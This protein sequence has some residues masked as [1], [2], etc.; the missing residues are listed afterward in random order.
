M[1]APPLAQSIP[2]PLVEMSPA[3]SEIGQ[4][5]ILAP[6]MAP[7]IPGPFVERAMTPQENMAMMVPSG[8]PDAWVQ[9][10]AYQ[11]E[12]GANRPHREPTVTMRINCQQGQ[13][14][15]S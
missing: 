5:R 2:A 12:S 15:L 8:E 7:K 3:S 11:G 10:R 1:H 9:C 14:S 4:E 6:L 13:S